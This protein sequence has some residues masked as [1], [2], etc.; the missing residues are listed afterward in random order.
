MGNKRDEN[1]PDEEDNQT[2]ANDQSE[3]EKESGE[4]SYERDESARGEAPDNLRRRSDWF[5]KRRR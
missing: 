1:G 4:D 3:A 2:D 5:Q